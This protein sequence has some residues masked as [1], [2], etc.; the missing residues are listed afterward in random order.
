MNNKEEIKRKLEIIKTKYP[1]DGD[2]FIANVS[3]EYEKLLEEKTF[4]SHPIF[5][6]I[7]SNIERWLKSINARLLNDENLTEKERDKMFATKDVYRHMLA[8][9]R[10]EGKDEALEGLQELIDSKL[11]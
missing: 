6:D 2:E 7:V 11:D 5:K 10:V 4:L 1:I 8:L 9:F 3:K